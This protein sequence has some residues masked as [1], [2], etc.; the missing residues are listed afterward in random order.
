M[1][2]T[3]VSRPVSRSPS[4]VGYNPT[5]TMVATSAN[6]PIQLSQV[7][8]PATTGGGAAAQASADAY[9]QQIAPGALPQAVTSGKTMSDYQK[10][11]GQVGM[12]LYGAGAQSPTLGGAVQQ[13][14]GGA[15]TGFQFGGPTGAVAGG[16]VGLGTGLFDY[17]MAREAEKET[18]AII[19]EEMQRQDRMQKSYDAEYRRQAAI[20]AER[21]DVNWQ[22]SLDQMEKNKFSSDMQI[23]DAF[24]AR[25]DS[26]KN[27]T[28][29]QSRNASMMA[30]QAGR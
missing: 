20:A 14:V 4:P 26:V 19:N 29:T 18:R 16:A 10:H 7:S 2:P 24:K 13:T 23:F 30:I 12:Q 21:G 6:N 11:A 15:M 8:L 3:P 17:Y 28:I 9:M 25:L 27:N 5:P 22:F 1:T